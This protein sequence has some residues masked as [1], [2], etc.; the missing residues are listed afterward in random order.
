MKLNQ[1][2]LYFYITFFIQNTK[3]QETTEKNNTIEIELYSNSDQTIE[4]IHLNSDEN[5]DMYIN[6]KKQDKFNNTIDL[7][8]YKNIS[9]ELIFSN[10]YDLIC[11]KLFK[12][13]K[14]IKKIKFNNFNL[15]KNMNYMFSGCSTLE[16]IDFSKF[17]TN[18]VT[19]MIGTFLNCSSL[20]SLDLSSFDTSSV[21]NM[22]YMF[23]GCSSLQSLDL[24]SFD[25]KLVNNMEYMFLG[26]N[27]LES[28]DLFSFNTCSVN[29]MRHM[30]S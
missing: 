7:K 19:E 4:F 29:N 21:N 15:C 22:E 27:S 20:Q 6:N 16:K 8:I 14:V 30:F 23:S 28:L 3:N 5:V 12:D 2:L 24:S 10:D 25:T 9:I 18:N 17:E 13:I 1:I 11:E 26:C